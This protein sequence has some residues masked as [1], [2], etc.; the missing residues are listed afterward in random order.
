MLLPARLH[1]AVIM[2]ATCSGLFIGIGHT[3]QEWFW[4]SRTTTY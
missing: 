1:D 3:C 4:L 2:L